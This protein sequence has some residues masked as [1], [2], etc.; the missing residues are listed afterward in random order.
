MNDK[1]FSQA[2]ANN[3]LPILEVLQQYLKGKE[4]ILEIGSG[5]GQHAVFFAEQ[6]AR[7]GNLFSFDAL[8]AVGPEHHLEPRAI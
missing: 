1:D 2:P 3:K 6:F 7:S 5:T 8:S 4:H